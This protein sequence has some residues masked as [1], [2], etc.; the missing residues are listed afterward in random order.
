M[1]YGWAILIIV[2][3]GA[4]LYYLGI[5]SPSTFSSPTGYTGFGAFQPVAWSYNGSSGDF[6][7][8]IGNKMDAAVTITK[9]QVTVDTTTVSNTT[10][11]PT[12][13][14]NKQA[15]LY[16]SGLPTKATGT[17]YTASIKIDYIFRSLS[18]TDSGQVSQYTT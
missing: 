10:N 4:A 7:L 9:F 8:T 1:T 3:V 6:Y 18:Y 2:L 14:K 16:V 13:S 11:L 17:A 5:F 12:I 15:T